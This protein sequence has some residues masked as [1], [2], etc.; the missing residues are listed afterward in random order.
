M[1]FQSHYNRYRPKTNKR[2]T[3]V[4]LT[5]QQFRA[6]SDINNIISK[7]RGNEHELAQILQQANDINSKSFNDFTNIKSFEESM[8]KVALVKEYFEA[9]PSQ[10]RARYN[11][12]VTEVFRAL[13]D[14]REYAFLANNGVLDK[15]IVKEFFDNQ[16]SSQKTVRST[17]EAAEQLAND[18]SKLP[19]KQST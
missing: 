9:L 6:S 13:H 4:S 12:D 5:Q 17:G 16:I 1:S 19:E 7:Y 15:K 2:F 3:Q 8:R 11:Q 10:V 18:N 14:P